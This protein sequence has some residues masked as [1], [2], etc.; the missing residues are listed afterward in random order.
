M[1]YKQSGHL[2][3]TLLIVFFDKACKYEMQTSIFIYYLT[4]KK[5]L[6]TCVG[7]CPSQKKSATRSLN[8][9]YKMQCI[10]NLQ[11]IAKRGQ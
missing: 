9:K 10:S 6:L 3:H 7:I 8:I 5:L 11:F 1:K 2:T 4:I